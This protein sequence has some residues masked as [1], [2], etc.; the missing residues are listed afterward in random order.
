[1]SNKLFIILTSLIIILATFLRFFQLGTNPPGFYVDEAA[2]GYNAF[3]ILHNGTD[4]Y[5]IRYPWFFQSFGDY[6]LPIPIYATVPFIRLIG[7]NEL[8]VRS[9]PAFFGVLSV[10]FMMLVAHEIAGKRVALFTGLLLAISPWHIHLS[11]WGAEYI[12]Y[13]TFLSAGV[14]FWLKSLQKPSYIVPTVVCFTLTFYTYYTALML[15]PIL[16]LVILVSY[17]RRHYF[18][19]HL[20]WLICGAAIFIFLSLPLVQGYRNGH[21]LSRWTNLQKQNPTED[22]RFDI[23]VTTYVEHFLPDF[24]FLKGDSG[25]TG[26]FVRHSVPGIGEM[27]LFDIPLLIIGIGTAIYLW[28]IGK[29]GAFRYS[30]IGMMA[31][32]VILYP[33]GSSVLTSG[34]YVFRSEIGVLPLVFF[35]AFGLDR[36]VHF[37]QS[38]V[39]FKFKTILI[40]AL[41]TVIAVSFGYFSYLQFYRY[42]LVA[43]GY[44]GW[45]YGYRQVVDYVKRHSKEYDKVYVFGIPHIDSIYFKFYDPERACKNCYV[46]VPENIKPKQ[47]ILV[48]VRAAEVMPSLRDILTVKKTIYFPNGKPGFYL[49]EFKPGTEAT[50]VIETR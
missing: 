40:V 37:C 35:S 10:I 1:M 14:Y 31:V 9:A 20:G 4:E 43:A 45:F 13:L 48:A 2:I 19:T 27:Y 33:V 8:A 6:R 49:A 26:H 38:Q 16:L 46:G 30:G 41:S 3:T 23:F 21:V 36:L 42:P 34:P 18:K 25:L 12:Y 50:A 28:Y 39:R 22:S 32:L 5:G 29:T 15:T 7:L 11:R 44:D 47:K 17:I 24:L